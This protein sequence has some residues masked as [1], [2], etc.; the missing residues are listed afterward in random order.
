MRKATKAPKN[1]YRLTFTDA[2]GWDSGT[3][4]N[5]SLENAIKRAKRELELG[6]S[7]YVTIAKA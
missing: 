4:E 6:L 7:H 1:A 2:D 5:L 3:A